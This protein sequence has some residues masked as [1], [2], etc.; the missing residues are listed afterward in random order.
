VIISNTSVQ[1]KQWHIYKRAT[2][3]DS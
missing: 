3:G 1:F 2:D